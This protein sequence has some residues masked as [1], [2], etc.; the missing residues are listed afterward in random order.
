MK[1]CLESLLVLG[2][3]SAS[4]AGCRS[5]RAAVG[6]EAP[7][8]VER[9][10]SAAHADPTKP[11]P[12]KGSG[13]LTPQP[14]A[15]R[16]A[17]VLPVQLQLTVYEVTTGPE[18]TG[19]LDART[20]TA[21]AMTADGLA[22]ALNR[23][24]TSR[25]LY[26]IDQPANVYSEI[27]NIGAREAVITDAR[28]TQ[29]GDNI[30]SFRY[31]NT[32]IVVRLSAQVPSKGQRKSPNVNLSVD[33]SVLTPGTVEVSPGVRVNTIRHL[34]FDHQEALVLSQPRLVF[35]TSSASTGQPS[36][37]SVYVVRY[38]FNPPAP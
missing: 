20:L 29:K 32:G 38:M 8:T 4:V 36:S 7:A 1:R 23:L 37:A 3:I 34:S 5:D 30:H 28:V 25:T 35:L 24:G 16:P 19:E 17:E 2:L 31:E 21:Q 18:R 22:K 12:P 11:N 14:E 27:I 13:A 33:L 9:P 10:D 15:R 6:S 26:A